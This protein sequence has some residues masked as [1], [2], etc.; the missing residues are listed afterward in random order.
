ILI[1]RH[2]NKTQTTHYRIK[3]LIS[4]W[5]IHHSKASN[6]LPLLL[7]QITLAFS[8][9]KKWIL[10]R[11]K[12]LFDLKSKRRRPVGIFLIDIEGE[13]MKSINLLRRSNLDKLIRHSCQSAN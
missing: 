12:N 6:N 13:L 4:L 9:F 1:M 7:Y 5:I 8:S 3:Y 10:V 11:I 2:L